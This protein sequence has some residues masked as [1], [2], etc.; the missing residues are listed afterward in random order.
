MQKTAIVLQDYFLNQVRKE[1]TQVTVHL[2][3]G[4]QIKGFVL[5]FDSFTFIM[6]VEGRQV[7]VY[8]HAVST[9]SPQKNIHLKNLQSEEPGEE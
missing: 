2:I 3:N 6:D 4:H 5:G 7:V 8:K 9:I 1:K